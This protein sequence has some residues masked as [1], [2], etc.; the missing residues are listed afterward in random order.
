M[1]VL[2]DIH[3]NRWALEAVLD[4]MA[5][6]GLSRCVN[7]GDCAYGPLDP[8]GTMRLLMAR[9]DP[10]VR[11]NEDRVL[12]EPGSAGAAAAQGTTL[13][14]VWQQLE[15]EQLSWLA[16]LP[17]TL[18]LDDELLLFHGTPD[19][20]DEYL[21]H[22][23]TAAGATRRTGADVEKRL[24]GVQARVV[25][26]GH[27]HIPATLRL[28]DGRMAV[29]PGSVGLPAYRDDIPRP[30][31]M[32]AGTPHARYC[33]LTSS[34]RDWNAEQVAIAYDWPAAAEA[35]LRNGRPDWARWLATG[36]S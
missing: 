11:G 18:G 12:C 10:T 22:A 15:P 35:A 13:G 14:Y 27:D 2:S 5:R 4:D 7:L 17:V 16:G 3:G 30:H 28:S 25:L 6:R 9:G 26:C 34:G 33:I 21:L 36:C 29:N 23:V 32:E 19:R 24:A 20:D 31:A 1:A 8:A